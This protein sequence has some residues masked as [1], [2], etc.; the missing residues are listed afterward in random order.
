MKSQSQ[1]QRR[2]VRPPDLPAWFVV[3]LTETCCG[4][5]GLLLE[6]P[7]TAWMSKV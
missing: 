3:M 7:L 1:R 5:K 6:T 4:G 2:A